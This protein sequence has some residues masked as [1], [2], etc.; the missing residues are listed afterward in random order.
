MPPGG[1]RPDDP[2]DLRGRLGGIR[3]GLIRP[4]LPATRGIQPDLPPE[5]VPVT[6]PTTP[7]SSPPAPSEAETAARERLSRLTIATELSGKPLK[8]A[9]RLLGQEA[10][11]SIRVDTSLE[12]D[13]SR[14]L[15]IST[16]GLSFKRALRGLLDDLAT[17]QPR[18][19]AVHANEV[20]VTI[21]LPPAAPAQP[22]ATP[23]VLPSAF[24]DRPSVQTKGLRPDLPPGMPSP[25][26]GPR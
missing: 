22:S 16:K 26:D 1:C 14:P 7:P 3:P 23:A 11:M 4:D 8:E 12:L 20:V 5:V 10:G 15:R 2:D 6:G 25:R 21:G 9:I 18:K 17:H 13:W 19:L 24:E